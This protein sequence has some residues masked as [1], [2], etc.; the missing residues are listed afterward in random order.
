MTRQSANAFAR[1]PI[2]HR[3]MFAVSILLSTLQAQA[4][5]LRISD[6]TGYPGDTISITFSLQGDGIT[7]QATFG[8]ESYVLNLWQSSITQ[9][10]TGASCQI[11]TY[12]SPSPLNVAWNGSPRTDL[13]DLCTIEVDLTYADSIINNLVFA[14]SQQCL[15]GSSVPTGCAAQAS[16]IRVLD[17]YALS[18][19]VVLNESPFSPPLSNVVSFDYNNTATSAPLAFADAPR[20]RTA[21]R[22]LDAIPGSTLDQWFRDNP[23][24][25][26]TRLHDYAAR[27]IYERIEQRDAAIAAARRDPTVREVIDRVGPSGP[28]STYPAMLRA[29]QPFGLFLLGLS[30]PPLWIET[31]GSRDITI[32]GFAIH[33]GLHTDTGGV[34]PGVPAPGY[35]YAIVSMPGLPA[36]QYTVHLST[37]GQRTLDVLGAASLPPHTKPIPLDDVPLWVLLGVVVIVSTKRLSLKL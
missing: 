6:A 2:W 10:A 36:G 3:M 22:E 18:F 23:S 11:G 20:P 12:G 19:I 17:S 16:S 33:L 13:I 28:T 1:W 37:G 25:P 5:E 32:D 30:C 14:R 24:S 31:P 4:A 26:L 35:T 29:G 34:C 8:I 9:Q 7:S 21:R 15:D 27:F